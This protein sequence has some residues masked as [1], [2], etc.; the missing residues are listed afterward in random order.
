MKQLLSI[1][2]DSKTSKGEKLGYLTGILY[3]APANESGVMNVCPHAS[4]GCKLACLFT[5]GRGSF[6][7]VR[8]ARIA[9][10]IYFKRDRAAFMSDLVANVHALIKKA[11][12]AGLKP[13]VR[14]NGTSD[15]PWHNIPVPGAPNIMSLFPDVPFYDYTPNTERALDFGRNRLPANY[16]L[17]YSRKEDNE[18]FARLVAQNGGNVAVVFSSK[19]LPKAYYGRPVIN[20]DESDLRFLDPRGVIVGLS[21]K[22]KAKKDTSGFVVQTNN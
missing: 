1:S 16:S 5:A 7:S 8:D 3:L 17:T 6:N 15:L 10:T 21:A 14:L 12:K 22:G 13:A 11:A 18:I 2:N 19:T 4:A 20:G 9:K